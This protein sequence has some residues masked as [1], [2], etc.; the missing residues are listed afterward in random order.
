M[1]G[2]AE[3]GAPAGPA[4]DE[5]LPAERRL[6]GY[7]GAA[8][9]AA[10]GGGDRRRSGAA[11][12]G[13]D[14]D[15]IGVWFGL[16][17]GHLTLGCGV[18]PDPF[19]MAHRLPNITTAPIRREG[20]DLSVPPSRRAPAA[21]GPGKNGPVTAEHYFTASPQAP[22]R[23]T[24]VE[25]AGPAATSGWR[26]GRRVLGRA[27][28]SGYGGTVRRAGCRAG[29]DPRRLLDL[30]CGYGPIAGVL[31]VAPEA[32]VYAVDVNP[33]AL[34]LTRRERG[35][36]RAGRRVVAVHPRRG[37]ADL[38]F[39]QIWSNPPI[40]VGKAELHA[41]LDVAAAARSRTGRLAGGGPAPG[42][43]LA[44]RW[45]AGGAGPWTGTPARR[46]TGC[47]GSRRRKIR[48]RRRGRTGR[49]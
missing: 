9:A 27:A 47:C 41:L 7:P 42:R 23:P 15:G 35:R 3:T 37:P 30:G 25:F 6:R 44:A 12:C 20:F 38:V 2:R 31:A 46:A 18:G 43:R 16:T 26:R 21:T 32:T 29:R 5:R 10:G 22:A 36:A 11:V 28:G 1:F 8:G 40:R 4:Q 39:E 19:V 33:R 24:E 49:M 34:E 48:R 14:N 17:A 45:L 13:A